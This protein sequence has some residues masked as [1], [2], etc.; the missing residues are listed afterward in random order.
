[1]SVEYT[2]VINSAVED[3]YAE[4][5]NMYT[6]S[7]FEQKYKELVDA[8]K[9]SRRPS[10]LAELYKMF[11]AC[12]ISFEKNKDNR[13]YGELIKKLSYNDKISLSG[14]ILLELYRRYRVYPSPKDYMT[15]IVNRLENK[16]D[17]WAENSLRLRIL[18]RFIKYGDYLSAAEFK[19]SKY[20]QDYVKNKLGKNDSE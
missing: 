10:C 5:C 8:G 6:V 15:R 20:I 11:R 3:L 16:S 13:Y 1:M 17:G 14:K 18:K 9:T 2:N 19:G 12:D 7:D 4:F